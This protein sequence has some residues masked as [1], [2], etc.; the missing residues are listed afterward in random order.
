M[1]AVGSIDELF[2][3]EY[4]RLVRALAVAEDAPH[5]ADAVQEAFIAAQ[6]R[7]ARVSTLDDPAAWVRRVAVNRLANGR[8]DRRRR[9]EILAGVRAPDPAEL[10]ALDLDLL[11]AVRSLPP[12]QRL[13]LCLHHLAGYAVADVAAMLEVTEGTVKSNLHDARTALRQRLEVPDDVR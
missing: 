13:T 3:R 2:Q 9:S 7:W 1:A 10:D 4:P 5:A 11:D 12:R 6:R 8:R